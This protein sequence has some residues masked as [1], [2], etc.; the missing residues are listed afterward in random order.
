MALQEVIAKQPWSVKRTIYIF[1]DTMLTLSAEVNERKRCSERLSEAEYIPSSV[2][3]GKCRLTHSSSLIGDPRAEALKTMFDADIAETRQKL[4]KHINDMASLELKNAASNKRNTFVENA[5]LLFQMLIHKKFIDDDIVN[6]AYTPR[7][8]ALDALGDFISLNRESDLL[9]YLDSTLDEISKEIENHKGAAT[10]P[11]TQQH[12]EEETSAMQEARETLSVILR[13]ITS[14]LQR[15][16]DGETRKKAKEKQ[17]EAFY[18]AQRTEEATAATAAALADEPTATPRT[19]QA[20]IR[21]EVKLTAE[22]SARKKL[23]KQQ[24]QLTKKQQIDKAAARKKSSGAQAG[25]NLGKKPTNAGK[26]KSLTSKE[27]TSKKPNEQSTD[28]TGDKRKEGRN[29]KQWIQRK[30]QKG[31]QRT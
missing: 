4:K 6:G 5:V 20:A 3:F 22:A 17:F 15:A 2:R 8:L 25:K 31:N 12:S 14:D 9:T 29:V 7:Q 16:V 27:T 26:S 28:R 13:P 18:A 21:K 11:G 10:A 23:K 1:S 19:L 30:K 24:Q